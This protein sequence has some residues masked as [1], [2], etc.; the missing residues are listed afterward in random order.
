[1]SASYEG[2]KLVA[3]LVLYLLTL[4]L[5]YV[6]GRKDTLKKVKRGDYEPK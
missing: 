6:V 2:Y 4:R 3:V 1:M 5:A